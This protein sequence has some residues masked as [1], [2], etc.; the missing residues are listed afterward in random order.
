MRKLLSIALLVIALF[1]TAPI[2]GLAAG[3]FKDV[4]YNYTFHEEIE[5]LSSKKI[6]SGYED[7]IFKPYNSVTRA[8]AAMMIGRALEL[9]GKAKNTKFRDVTANVTGSGYIASAIEKG[10]IYRIR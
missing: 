3:T 5:F 8:E 10:I 9:D 4:A 2:S 7:G 6:I 1:L